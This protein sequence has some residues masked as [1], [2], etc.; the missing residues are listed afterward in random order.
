MVATCDSRWL[1]LF[2]VKDDHR[3]CWPLVE[4]VMDCLNVFKMSGAFSLLLLIAQYVIL[5]SSRLM[6]LQL[7]ANATVLDL[8][9]S[10][11]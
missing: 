1:G 6:P 10:V 3:F 5:G 9:A 2:I 8:P 4:S 7:P 11:K